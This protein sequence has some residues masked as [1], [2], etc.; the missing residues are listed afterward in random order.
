MKSEN[1]KIIISLFVIIALII[2]VVYVRT[3]NADQDTLEIKTLAEQGTVSVAPTKPST[4]TKKTMEQ[5]AKNGDTL[6]M[7]YTGRLTDGT[8]FDSNVDPNFGHAEPFMFVLGA[9]RVIR[10]WDE[11]MVGMKVGEK[12]TLT[13]PP[14]KAYGQSGVGSIPPNS[15]LVFDVELLAIK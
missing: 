7:N 8:V 13:I 12:K 9:G 11:G 5:T 1:K 10:G 2:L 3:H 6:Y 15:T 4:S 14:E